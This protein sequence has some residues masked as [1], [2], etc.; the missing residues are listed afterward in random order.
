MDA[1]TA[2]TFFIEWVYANPGLPAEEYAA[3]CSEFVAEA[4]TAER[5]A[6]AKIAE[7]QYEAMASHG[8]WKA[9]SSSQSIADA[10]RNR[11]A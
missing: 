9:A 11:G 4:V 6:C 2:A 7:A 3:K 5:E 1:E 10:I 8:E